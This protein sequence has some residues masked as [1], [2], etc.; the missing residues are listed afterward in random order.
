MLCPEVCP[1]EGRF[2]NSELPRLRFDDLLRLRLDAMH[3][4]PL[5][6]RDKES[7]VVFG[8]DKQIFIP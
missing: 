2:A 3:H 6:L 1:L 5:R 7:I 4:P 8:Y